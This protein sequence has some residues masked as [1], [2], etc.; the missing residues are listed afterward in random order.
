MSIGTLGGFV[1][2]DW[3]NP[4]TRDYLREHAGLAPDFELAYDD[5][6]VAHTVNAVVAG[7]VAHLRWRMQQIELNDECRRQAAQ[8]LWAVQARIF[9]DDLD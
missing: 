8:H 9:G 4:D 7:E 6:Y 1:V 3:S 5:V 2:L